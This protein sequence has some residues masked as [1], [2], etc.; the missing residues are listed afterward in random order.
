MAS[1]EDRE[2]EGGRR[3]SYIAEQRHKQSQ[4]ATASVLSDALVT[5]CRLW[6]L[7]SPRGAGLQLYHADIGAL[8]NKFALLLTVE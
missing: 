8:L 3:R 4:G 1:G 7:N 5:A 2:R 6:K